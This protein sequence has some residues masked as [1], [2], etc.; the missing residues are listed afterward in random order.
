MT[1][2]KDAIRA[3]ALE[4]GFDA[5]GF[6][7]AAADP[8]WRADLD[9]YLTEGRH[10]EMGWMAETVERR[11]S[12]QGLWP[13]VQ[14]VIVLGANY[15]PAGDPL[16]LHRHPERGTVSVYA[17]NKDYHDLV[18]RRLKQLARWMVETYGG[19]LKVFVDTAPVMEKPLAG[20]SG[21]G[22]RGR[23]TNLVSRSFGSWLFLSEIYTTLELPPDPPEGDHCGK[24]RAC[25]DS[26]PTGAIE[27]FGRIDPRRCISYLTI[28]H[29]G[30][31]P[32]EL[33]PLMGNRIYGC[34]DCMAVCPWNKFARPTRE[35]DFLPRAELMA[36]R[37]ADL[38]SLDDAA[39]REVF[40]GSPVKRVGRDRFVR[41]VLIAI[42]NSGDGEL[43]PVAE[44]LLTDASPLVRGAAVWTFQRLKGPAERQAAK[45]RLLEDEKD[46]HVRQ[47]WW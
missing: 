3:K 45:A 25:E 21:L 12:P 37:L 27:G 11:A 39:F 47:E 4:I 29:K 34:D 2:P 17:R 5:V 33:R 6:A 28:E 15:G 14:S 41:N 1:E 26:C 22:W 13:E 35:P 23:H 24:C 43:G 40:S 30:P 9:A 46:C 32:V 8:Q 18:K 16:A 42:G 19:E 38:A 20:R 10:G 36:P 7:S 31:I 44:R